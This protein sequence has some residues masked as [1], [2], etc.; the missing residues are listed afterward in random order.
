LAGAILPIITADVAVSDDWNL[1]GLLDGGDPFP[2][3]VAAVALLAGASVQSNRAQAAALGDVSQFHADDFVV[4]PSGAEFH[5]E[6][7]FH[8]GAHR[9]KNP[10]DQWQIAQQ[11]GAAVALHDF[12]RRASKIQIDEVEAQVFDQ[13]RGVGQYGRIAAEELGGDGVLVLIKMKVPSADALVAHHSVG[14]GELGHDQP[15]STEVFDEAAENGVGHAGH[16]CEDGCGRD[17]DAA[18]LE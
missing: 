10:A 17:A 1:D 12:L 11:A 8:G 16:G 13:A 9:F 14:R 4:V 2:A 15:A 7:D 18:N 5:G 3:R 6:G